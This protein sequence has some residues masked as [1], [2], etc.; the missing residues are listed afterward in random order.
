VWPS[1]VRVR[2]LIPEIKKRQA[3]KSSIGCF[4]AAHSGDSLPVD[5]KFWNE[6]KKEALAKLESRQEKF[7][8]EMTRPLLARSVSA[9]SAAQG[10]LIY[11]S[12]LVYFGERDGRGT[13]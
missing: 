1:R 3:R 10:R 2:E 12:N 9:R 7:A 13:R 6:L 8:T 5:A 4:L 11:W